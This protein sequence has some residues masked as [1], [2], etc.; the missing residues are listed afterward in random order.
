VT[1][2]GGGRF[3]V[4]PDSGNNTFM[5]Q[6]NRVGQRNPEDISIR[7]LCLTLFLCTIILVQDLDKADLLPPNV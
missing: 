5:V 2:T 3:R 4:I 6:R 1:G 7:F